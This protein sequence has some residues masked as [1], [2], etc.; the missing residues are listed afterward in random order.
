M[1]IV[2]VSNGEEVITTHQ[3]DEGLVLDEISKVHVSEND[4]GVTEET[5]RVS[6]WV[7]DPL[8][9]AHMKTIRC[10]GQFWGHPPGLTR[11]PDLTQPLHNQ[12]D[13]VPTS[14]YPYRTLTALSCVRIYAVGFQFTTNKP[15]HERACLRAPEDLS[16]AFAPSIDFR[17]ETWRR[18][19]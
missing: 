12:L 19:I 11:K 17:V 4:L 10:R 5:D 8:D 16:R 2:G 15:F 14:S 6:E 1:D 13:P 18:A 9:D 7:M 3:E